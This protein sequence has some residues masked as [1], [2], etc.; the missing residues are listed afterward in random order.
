MRL[1]NAFSVG[2]VGV[3]GPGV[4]ADSNP[5]LELVN[6]FGVRISA[7]PKKVIVYVPFPLLAERINATGSGRIV[8]L[9]KKCGAPI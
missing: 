2:N 4:L 6:A 9:A 1:A 3:V 5:G 7:L 8:D